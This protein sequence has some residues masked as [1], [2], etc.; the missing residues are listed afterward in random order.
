MG[1]LDNKVILVTGGTSG[2]GRVSAEI[3]AQEGAKVAITG[4]RP[5][6]GAAVVEESLAE[7]EEIAQVA[8]F[9][10]SDRSSYINGQS[11][12]VDGGQSAS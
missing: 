7:P 5:A 2:I 12:V 10:L 11:I 1:L 6:E 8:L 4:R 9:L 3:F